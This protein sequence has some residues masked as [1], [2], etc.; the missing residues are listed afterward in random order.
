MGTIRAVKINPVN[1]EDSQ[2][3][4]N[5]L[6]NFEMKSAAFKTEM[7]RKGWRSSKSL[8]PVIMQEALAETA[9]SRNLLSLG[10]R[11]A[12]IDSEGSLKSD[13]FLRSFKIS[14]LLFLLRYLSNLGCKNTSQ[15]SLY[16]SRLEKTFPLSIAMSIAFLGLRDLKRKALIRILVSNTKRLF[17]IQQLLKNFFCE[18][19][20]GSFITRFIQEGLK[21]SYLDT[22]RQNIYLVLNVFLKLAF[23]FRRNGLP[24]PGYGIL[25][26]NDYAFH[27]I[28]FKRNA[29]I[30][31]KI[32]NIE[33]NGKPGC[34]SLRLCYTRTN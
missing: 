25:Y 2:D 8:S 16:V 33:D 21:L 10:S 12:A 22:L 3:I 23:Y 27:K 9:N 7:P 18:A 4:M 19:I 14:N 6:L 31:V 13:S 15:S 32:V 28:Q 17:L 30:L 5:Q 20:F 24:F 34:K 29:D 26:I 11:Q 1:D